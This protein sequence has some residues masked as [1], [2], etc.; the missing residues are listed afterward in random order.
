MPN[1]QV[2]KSYNSIKVSGG[3]LDNVVGR[4]GQRYA[5]RCPI[6]NGVDYLPVVRVLERYCLV[7]ACNVAVLD[8]G[9]VGSRDNS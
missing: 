5:D 1:N 6:G 3:I 2:V 8:H 4:S 7:K 9:A